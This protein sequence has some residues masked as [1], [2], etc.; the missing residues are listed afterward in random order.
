MLGKERTKIIQEVEIIQ[1][2]V[3]FQ[4][5]WFSTGTNNS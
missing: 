2:F 4:D 1:D 3:I 5:V